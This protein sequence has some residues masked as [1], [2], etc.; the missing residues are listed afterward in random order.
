MK[1]ADVRQSFLDFFKRRDH[2]IVPSSPVIP[3]NDPTLLFTNAG[4]NQFKDVFTGKRRVDYSRAASAQKCLR[5]G[6]KHNDLDNVG[7]TSHHHTFF[8]MLGN[9][10]FGDYF[11]E[12][13]ILYAWEWV[14]KELA[15][16]VDRL[17]A[18]VYE[19]DDEA[20]NLWA[21]VASP[22]KAGRILRF[23]KKDNYWAMGDTGPCGPCSELHIDR[24]ERFGTQPSDVINGGTDRFVEIWN[25][26]FM[27]Y[28]QQPDGTIVE[29]PKPSVDTGAGLER[30]TAVVQNA[31]SNYEIDI[32]KGLIEAISDITKS[33]YEDNKSSHH[34]IADHVRALTFAIADGAGISNEGQ[35]YVL[36]RILRRAAFHGRLLGVEDPF[37]FRLV[38]C[39][40]DEMGQTYSEIRERQTLIQN[41]IRVEEET[42]ARTLDNGLRTFRKT[43]KELLASGQTIVPGRDVFEL[44]DTYGFPYDLTEIIAREYNLTLDSSGYE[45]ALREQQ[46]RS[47]QS[48]VFKDKL[49]AH[50]FT[51]HDETEESTSPTNFNPWLKSLSVSTVVQD[52]NIPEGSGQETEILVILAD[53]PFYM[54]AG[55]QIADVGEIVAVDGSFS[56]RVIGS[57]LSKD[58]I[59]IRTIGDTVAMANIKKGVEVTAT[60]DNAIRW[61]IM[62][63]HT[64]T[65]LTHAALRKVLG[66][67]VKQSGSYV[68]PDRL[69][70]DYSHHQPM[71]PEEIQAV[72]EMVNAE[73]LKGTQVKTE[74]M[75]V[76]S[77]KNAGAMALFGEKY[78]DT[79][80]VVSVE[81]FSK[82]LCGG[83]HVSNTSQIGPFFITLET[84]IASGVRRL[85]AIT[86][87]EA[88][89]YMLSA[90]Q[91][92]RQA[93]LFVGRTEAEAL[94]A[95]E[96]LRDGNLA[97]QKELKRLKAELYSGGSRTLGDEQMIGPLRVVTHD[98][99]PVD[100]DVMAGW[101]DA[102]KGSNGAVLAVALGTVEGKLTYMA[103]ASAEAV[104]KFHVHIGRLS[105]QLL[106]RFGGRGGGKPSFAQG[107]VAVETTPGELFKT[108]RTLVSAE[109]EKVGG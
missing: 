48:S 28:D 14:T 43:A 71:T 58:R 40:V 19:T 92:R 78:G 18:T 22:L 2:R 79:V 32:F 93:A 90:K 97:L 103:S 66:S 73:I 36:R 91:F 29:L 89:N 80:R 53:S 13:A 49:V 88:I 4:M 6:G 23:S 62:R 5:A 57:F 30:L 47:R 27:Q 86:G 37:M 67:H 55:G 96:Q 34:V 35:G 38:K 109:V 8:E 61:D 12:Q 7:F 10:S 11:K 33:R 101:I 41:V 85:E 102:Q 1:T 65:H 104:S 87:R 99:G 26:V 60:V 44:Q 107:T 24:G 105:R 84:S 69:R 74:P 3:F 15:L 64:A 21:K 42:F 56:L 16:P 76:E 45:A 94:A 81:G 98:F 54:E 72:E 82:E 106:E 9:F 95:V 59:V 51:L 17:Y 46:E 68:G 39:V 31:D 108:A 63:N 70:F 83:T 50:S 75:D 25:L 77:A 20:F 100:P 52:F